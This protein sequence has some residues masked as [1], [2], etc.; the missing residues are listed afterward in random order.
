MLESISL[1]GFVFG[2]DDR[3]DRQTIDTEPFNYQNTLSI[4]S[5][6]MNK[7]EL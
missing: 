2:G 7:D 6:G 1:G 3:K 5:I 4:K